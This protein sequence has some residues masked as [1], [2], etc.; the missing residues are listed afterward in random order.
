MSN[1]SDKDLHFTDSAN[2]C[3][4][5]RVFKG[6]EG[7]P[8][9]DLYRL[10]TRR[11]SVVQGLRVYRGCTRIFLGMLGFPALL[12]DHVVGPLALE[13]Q[14]SHALATAVA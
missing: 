13:F 11:S 10:F 8:H 6:R 14:V 12:A 3:R 7:L 4:D 2:G 5:N 9:W 1:P